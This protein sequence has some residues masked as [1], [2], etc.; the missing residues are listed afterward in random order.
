MTI[1]PT[2]T[3]DE[4]GL[5]AMVSILLP[6]HIA[7]R[8]PVARPGVR[9][10]LSLV[11]GTRITEERARRLHDA[12]ARK[13][14][15]APIPRQIVLAGTGDYRTDTTP[16]PIV[17]LNVV[18]GGEL[19][20]FAASLDAAHDLTRR[21]PFHPHVTLAS[22]NLRDPDSMPDT[23]LDAIAARFADFRAEFPVTELNLTLGTGTIAPPW[24]R[25]WTVSESYPMHP[26]ARP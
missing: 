5:F 3:P 18:D 9:P 14:F 23:E 17:Y 20:A 7:E 12:L 6:G 16:M 15:T 4:P 22:R 26:D 25:T 19:A 8:L 10:H 21:I 2:T 1:I 13:E 11:G 24:R